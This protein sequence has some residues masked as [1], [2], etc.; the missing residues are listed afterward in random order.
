METLTLDVLA[1]SAKINRLKG[2][3][4]MS[5]QNDKTLII[6]KYMVHIVA[7]Y[8]CVH[9][10]VQVEICARYYKG[11]RVLRDCM[12]RQV[13]CKRHMKIGMLFVKG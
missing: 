2:S 13:L 4:F 12:K 3:T 9:I 6:G 5:L 10:C 1:F 11:D 7:G 8:S